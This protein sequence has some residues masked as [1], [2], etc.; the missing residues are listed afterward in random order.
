[1][2]AETGVN[3]VWSNYELLINKAVDY[4]VMFPLNSPA[5]MFDIMDSFNYIMPLRRVVKW[6]SCVHVQMYQSYC[7]VQY[8][9]LS[10]LFNPELEVPD[11]ERLKQ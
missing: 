9:I 3:R 10:L 7:C 6:F 11:I 4:K 5:D 2:Q 1:M 8:V